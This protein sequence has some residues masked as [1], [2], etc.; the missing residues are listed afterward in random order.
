MTELE[1]IVIMLTIIIYSLGGIGAL[2]YW[3]IYRP[4]WFKRII[5]W[6]NNTG[7]EH[8]DYQKAIKY[9]EK[10]DVA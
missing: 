4:K 1:N 5:T 10:K 2:Y 7:Y 3:F 6:S 8:P 9:F